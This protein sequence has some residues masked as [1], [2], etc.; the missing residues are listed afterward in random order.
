MKIKILS[1]VYCLLSINMNR[2][3]VY[4][5]S[6]YSITLYTQHGKI[7]DKILARYW[8]RYWQDIG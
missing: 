4:D 3:F 6:Y 1:I 2:I 8:I 7:L 5:S